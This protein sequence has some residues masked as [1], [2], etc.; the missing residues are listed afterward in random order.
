MSITGEPDQLQSRPNYRNRRSTFF[1]VIYNCE[2]QVT[3]RWLLM[4]FVPEDI[5]Q[6]IITAY[7]HE[8]DGYNQRV[9]AEIAEMEKDRQK[10]KAGRNNLNDT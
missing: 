2:D 7:N 4:A 8:I 5:K 10:H 6:K 9:R 3:V 1:G